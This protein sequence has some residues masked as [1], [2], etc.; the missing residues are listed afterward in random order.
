MNEANFAI[1]QKSKITNLAFLAEHTGEIR[2]SVW[3]LKNKWQKTTP[4]FYGKT[5]HD[6]SG[7]KNADINQLSVFSMKRMKISAFSEPSCTKRRAGLPHIYYLM[8]ETLFFV[9]AET[10]SHCCVKIGKYE[11]QIIAW[12]KKSPARMIE[13]N[14]HTN[15][16][17]MRAAWQ[18]SF[19]EMYS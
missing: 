3:E 16:D 6:T 11:A 15:W 4:V 18:N 19:E 8:T 1:T 7:Q 13:E 9:F 12:A 14:C 10:L 2:F 5:L 17:S